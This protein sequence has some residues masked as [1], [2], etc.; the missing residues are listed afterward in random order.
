MDRKYKSDRTKRRWITT[1][2]NRIFSSA[3]E[4]ASTS[5][6]TGVHVDSDI[7]RKGGNK[8][9]RRSSNYAADGGAENMDSN[10]ITNNIEEQITSKGTTF[11]DA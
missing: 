11:F 2:F 4:S 3:S 6:K 7:V 1:E 9:L 10:N 5:D 8:R